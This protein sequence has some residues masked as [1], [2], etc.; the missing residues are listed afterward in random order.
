M[1]D[2]LYMIAQYST[3]LERGESWKTNPSELLGQRRTF[4]VEGAVLT[5]GSP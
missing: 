2:G 5:I 3:L 1:F 4:L